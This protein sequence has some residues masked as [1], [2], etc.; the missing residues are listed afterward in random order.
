MRFRAGLLFFVLTILVAIGCRK[1]L[2]PNVD[3]NQAPETWITAA[4]LDTITIKDGNGVPV[5]PPQIGT[6]PFRYHLYWAG[7]DHDGDVAGF[8]FAV[9]E[10]VPVAPPGLPSVPALPGPKPADYHFTAKTDSIFIFRVSEF[11]PDRQ[12]AF[13][14][15]AVDNQ[16]KA[17]ATPARLVFNALDRNPPLPIIE[18]QPKDSQGRPIP[19]LV[20]GATGFGR[21]AFMSREGN[22]FSRDT[23]IFINDSLTRFNFAT[24][25]SDTIPATARIDIRWR[26]EPTVLGT[27]V[28]GYRYKLDEPQF[29][30]VDSSVHVVTYNTG[31]NGDV[32]RPGSKVFTLKAVDQAGGAR[33]IN[34]RFQMNFDPDTWF[35]GPD[36]SL[37]PIDPVTGTRSIAV[38]SWAALPP[39]AGSL[40]S[41]DSLHLLPAQ[42]PQRRTFF[43][44]YKDRLYVHEEGDT[45]HMNSWVILHGG[46]SDLDSP[47]SIQLGPQDP[48]LG[49][50]TLACGPAPALAVRPAG[51]N[52]NPIGLKSQYTYYYYPS[53]PENTASQ[54][55]Q[56]PLFDITS[57]FRAPTIGAYLGLRQSGKVYAVLRSQDGNGSFDRRIDRARTL[58]EKVDAGM[59]SP[60]EIALR[61]RIMTFYV[62]FP[63]R[64]AAGATPAP[65]QSFPSR[66]SIT[67]NMLAVD[68]DPFD[69]LTAPASSGGPSTAT[70]LR[71]FIRVRGKNAI[72]ENVTFTP[73]PTPFF[74]PQVTFDLPDNIVST[75]LTVD[76]ELC[77]CAA[78]EDTPGS[79]RCQTYSVPIVVPPPAPSLKS[80]TNTQSQPG[81]GQ[82]HEVRSRTP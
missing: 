71:W 11:S 74:N 55:V 8:Y 33:E 29:V 3:R 79:G 24:P 47:Y 50:D 37:Y 70:I 58:A 57:V 53:G 52:G 19:P 45:V 82:S 68:D 61:S 4:P 59:G 7:A 42:R 10:T 5:G 77:D 31:I 36:P 80:S 66:Q 26:G 78:C 20:G 9:V 46:G 15:Y 62:D 54:S 6:I 44:I 43:E 28:T 81:P 65:G 22:L 67:F 63:P 51:I 60:Q 1:P 35:A 69:V 21:I 41:C 64:L 39:Q 76:I 38:S 25:T 27:Y 13:F 56:F 30:A 34:R 2:T 48:D 23:L 72:G 73:F 12:H 14:I 17:D 40:L 18:I 49:P 32:I 75:D 16:G